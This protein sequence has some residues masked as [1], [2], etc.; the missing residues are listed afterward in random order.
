MADAIPRALR[1]LIEEQELVVSRHQA[2]A[3]GMSPHSLAHRL[4]EGGPWQILLPGVY[5]TVTGTALPAQMEMA[6]ILYGTPKP[7]TADAVHPVITGAAA[8]RYEGV[9]LPESESD[10]IDLLVPIGSRRQS[11][12][13]VAVHRTARMPTTV[14][15]RGKR[16]FALDAR[17]V[18]DAARGM[19]SLRDVRALVSSAVQKGCCSV[20]AIRNE[21]DDGPAR[22]SALLAR[23]VAEAYSGTRSAPEAELRDLIGKAR[24]P[25]PLFNPRL[26]LPDGT[27]IGKPDA[28]WPEA[29]VAAEVDSR[30]W[31]LRA[32]DWEHTMDRHSGLGQ[33]GIVTLHISP[34]KLRK[35]PTFVINRIRNAVQAGSAR[36]RLNIT[37]VPS[38]MKVPL[39]RLQP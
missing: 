23:A 8:L 25:M 29:G 37:T 18:A 12:S 1:A 14:I 28:W 6:A 16:S 9:T 13:F 20:T 35:D 36:P 3:A 2:I 27:F 22:G 34:Q 33:Y 4:R 26:Y 38:G 5:L 31:H 15:A 10:T 19:T 30:E 39:L 24:L 17:A 7:R 11:A 21:L 32:P